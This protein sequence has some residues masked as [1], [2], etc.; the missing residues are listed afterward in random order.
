MTDDEWRGTIL[1]CYA[2]ALAARKLDD[3]NFTGL[4]SETFLVHVEG[5]LELG[6]KTLDQDDRAGAGKLGRSLISEVRS[7]VQLHQEDLDRFPKPY[8]VRSSEDQEDPP[9]R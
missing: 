3:G 4:N 7:L 8:L 9:S 6:I 2:I 1:F 5:Q